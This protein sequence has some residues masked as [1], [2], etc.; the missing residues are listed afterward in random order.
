MIKE[1]T[2]F[3][4]V[5]SNSNIS[6]TIIKILLMVDIITIINIINNLLINLANII[7][8]IKTKTQIIEA[9]GYCIQ[10]RDKMTNNKNRLNLIF[11]V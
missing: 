8:K 6:S 3:K 7:I 4:E 1:M 11:K 2:P 9:K 5:I 10:V